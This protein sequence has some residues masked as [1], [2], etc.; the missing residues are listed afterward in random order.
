VASPGGA[1]R[2]R[3]CALGRIGLWAGGEALVVGERER[4]ID[5]RVEAFRH[6]CLLLHQAGILRISYGGEACFR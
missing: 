4:D 2:K 3:W 1:N 6:M 5:Y